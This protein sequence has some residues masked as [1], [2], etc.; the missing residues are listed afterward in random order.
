MAHPA[1]AQ[2]MAAANSGKA[3]PAPC[4]GSTHGTQD[5]FRF[6][7]HPAG[8]PALVRLQVVSYAHDRQSERTPITIVRVEVEEV[9][10]IWQ[11]IRLEYG[12]ACALASN[13]K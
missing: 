2:F 10:P 7:F 1:T 6:A 4:R 13:P 8:Q 9:G 5:L 3:G 11:G 12:G